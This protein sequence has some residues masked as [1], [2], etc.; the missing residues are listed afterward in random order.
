MSVNWTSELTTVF[1]RSPLLYLRYVIKSN[2]V[3]MHDNRER[4]S[5]LYLY[6]DT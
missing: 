3:S 5:N 1:R 2:F 6:V 4:L